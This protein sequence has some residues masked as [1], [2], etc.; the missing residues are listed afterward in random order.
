MLVGMTGGFIWGFIGMAALC[1]LGIA[2]RNRVLAVVFGILGLAVC[3]L[4]GILQFAVVAKQNVVDAALIASV[5]Y[6]V[7]DVISVAL[8]LAVAIVLRRALNAA[9][10]ISDGR[11]KE[12]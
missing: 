7:K 3:H 5:P 6:L 11:T 2:C 12:A 4:I 1:G 10:M 9:G 8:A